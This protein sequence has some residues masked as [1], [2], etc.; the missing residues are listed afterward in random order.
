VVI[1]TDVQGFSAVLAAVVSKTLTNGFDVTAYP[2]GN[3]ASFTL[4]PKL[5]NL[6][7]GTNHGAF[8]LTAPA[9]DC[10]VDILVT[11]DATAGAITF[12]GFTVGSNTGD[13]LGTTNTNKFLIQVRRI[14]GV[15]TYRIAALQ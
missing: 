11:N 13:A 7:Y 6:Q 14:N 5:G 15:S 10:A 12:S 2:L 1:G 3:I 8:T 4:D 9:S